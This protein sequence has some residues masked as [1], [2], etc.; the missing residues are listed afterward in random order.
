MDGYL[1]TVQKNTHK[2]RSLKS[3]IEINKKIFRTM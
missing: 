2:E 1:I 3:D